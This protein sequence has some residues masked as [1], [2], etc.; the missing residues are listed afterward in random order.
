[1]PASWRGVESELPGGPDGTAAAFS[2][3]WD[4][5]K[6]RWFR[7]FCLEMG[8]F[9]CYAFLASSWPKSRH[10]TRGVA[11]PRPAAPRLTRPEG[12]FSLD[13]RR[14]INAAIR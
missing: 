6:L 7:S 11:P 14:D 4:A 2:L 3:T 13:A 1:M 12:Q 5:A 8:Q 10:P 9:R